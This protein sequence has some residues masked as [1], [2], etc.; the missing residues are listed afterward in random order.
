MQRML[1]L[2]CRRCSNLALLPAAARRFNPFTFSW[3]RNKVWLCC[4]AVCAWRH[5]VL[6]HRCIVVPGAQ[7]ADCCVSFACV[8]SRQVAARE[9]IAWMWGHRPAGKDKVRCFTS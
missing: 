2:Q 5:T 4:N 8:C 1:S 9:F 6:L 3:D 7:Q